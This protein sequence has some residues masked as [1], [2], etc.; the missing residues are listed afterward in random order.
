MLRQQRVCGL[1]LTPALERK[2]GKDAESFREAIR[3]L[4]IPVVVVDRHI[5]AIKLDGVYY[6][7]YESGYIAASELVKAGNK[8]IAIITGDLQLRIARERFQGFKQALDDAGVELEEKFVLNG[9]FGIE[10]AYLLTKGMLDSGDIPDGIVTSNNRTS[11]GFI[12]ALREKRLQIGKDIA[13][14][15]IDDIEILNI[16][17]FNFSCVSRD[18]SEMGRAAMRLI[19][20]RLENASD[21]RVVHFVPCHLKLRGSEKRT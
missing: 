3:S 9:D 15:G 2:I 14:I 4:D 17:K 12:K 8:R 19:L 21:Q 16:L 5:D 10:T 7:N 20:D 11:I 13:V 1:I 18:T 6:E